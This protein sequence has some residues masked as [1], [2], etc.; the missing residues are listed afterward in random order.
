[1][2]IK[3]F[4][5]SRLIIGT[6]RLGDWGVKMDTASLESFVEEC[7]ALGL[8]DFDHADIYGDYTTEQDFGALLTIRP[9]LRDKIRLTTKCGIKMLSPNRPDH[10]IKSY[11]S[12][13]LHI[14]QS[15]ENSLKVLKTDFID[16]LLIHRP[17]F[18]M[19][20]QELAEAFESLQ[21]AGKVL[22]FGVSNFTTS[23]FELLHSY[24][25]LVTNQ[26]EISISHLQP[27]Y[28]GSLD[29]CLK[30]N[31]VPTAWSSLGGGVL[32]QD[33]KDERVLRIRKTGMA[34]AEK[35]GAQLDQILLAWL[36]KH[37][38]GIIPV[39]GTSKISRVK[40]ALAA[41]NIKLS[42]EEWYELWQAS[43][44]TEVP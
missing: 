7:L 19:N 39:L 44:G 2:G 6:M 16:L 29:Q 11:D 12:S 22:H 43:V 26:I 32:F 5:L 17:D 37:P 13:K 15:V 14:L 20:P 9:D 38:S 4:E 27:F 28:D 21:K 33:T 42:H 10:K 25:P 23:Q 30:Y 36:M 3:N 18:L 35:Y 40:S 41:C 24:F 1:M 34:L 31:I 8:K